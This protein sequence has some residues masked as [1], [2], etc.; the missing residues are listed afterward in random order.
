MI[1]GWRQPSGFK[2]SEAVKSLYGKRNQRIFV[3]YS[4][5]R[6]T[7]NGPDINMLSYAS[8]IFGS[9]I[10]ASGGISSVEDIIRIKNI[11]CSA[12]ILGKSIYDGKIDVKK[13]RTVV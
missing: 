2:V 8:N 10:I 13:A 7:L 12:V 9:K 5:K 1:D 3:N 6:C 4:R 11:G